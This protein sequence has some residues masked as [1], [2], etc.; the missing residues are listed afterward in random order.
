MA[1]YVDMSGPRNADSI[2]FLH[3]GGAGAWMWKRQMELFSDFHC[4]VPDLPEHD[5]SSAIRPFAISKVAENVADLIQTNAH[6]GIA[7]VVGLSLGAQV[8][9]EML[10]VAPD[11]VRSA[12]LSSP[13]LKSPPGSG[14]GFYNAGILRW[15]Y[16]VFIAPFRNWDWWIKLN[17]KYS[18]G[19]PMKFYPQFKRV[20][21]TLTEDAW[22]HITIE[23]SKFRI[24]SGLEKIETPVLAVAG[25][26]EY[27]A[28]K[29]SIKL[30]AQALPNG[31][32]YFLNLPEK[33]G[34]AASH[35]W[36]LTTPDLFAQSVRAWITGKPLPHEL[37]LIY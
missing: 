8:G 31:N 16:R 30:L 14:L 33:S 10:K 35:N 11:K 23:N 24:P 37:I 12:F 34:M 1:L 9:V 17:M 15:S 20:F 26:H 19:I 28:M 3:G 7:H 29:D 13:L 6:G 2:V 22:T 18:A 5:H 36:A 32:G 4:L 21:Q 25:A 27:R